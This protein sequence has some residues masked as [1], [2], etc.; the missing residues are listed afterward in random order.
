MTTQK[1]LK[2]V[3]EAAKHLE[4][5]QTVKAELNTFVPPATIELS[6]G[7]TIPFPKLTWRKE[8]LMLDLIGIIVEKVTELEHI[9]YAEAT[10]TEMI[11]IAGKVMRTVPEQ[12]T[13][14]VCLAVNMEAEEVDNQLDS[15]DILNILIP[16]F[17]D[18]VQR[19]TQPFQTRM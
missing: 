6:N 1:E 18:R 8:K 11:K 17:H 9:D 3:K 19:I 4:V 10:M 14:L 16:L 2:A 13:E 12:V 7:S 5:T 15:G